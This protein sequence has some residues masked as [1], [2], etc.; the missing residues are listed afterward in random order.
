LL[1]KSILRRSKTIAAIAVASGISF[2]GLAPSWATSFSF[3]SSELT[4]RDDAS[5]LS[6]SGGVIELQL[7]PNAQSKAGG[8]FSNSKLN[9]NQNFVLDGE[10]YLGSESDGVGADGI[11]FTLIPEIPSAV[12]SDGD[13]MGYNGLPDVFAI[14]WDTFHN[15]SKGDLGSF[16]DDLSMALNK[17]DSNHKSSSP[18]APVQLIPRS[19]M[20]ADNGTYRDFRISWDAAEEEITVKYDLNGDSS[21]ASAETIFDGVNVPMTSTGGLFDSVGGEVHWG[22][23]ASTGL[24]RNEQK[25]RLGATKTTTPYA[26][27]IVTDI[28][29]DGVGGPFEVSTGEMVTVQG[30]RLGSVSS[31][32]IDGQS[33]AVAE[34][35]QTSFSFEMPAEV[36]SGLADIVVESNLGNLRFYEALL[37]TEAKATDTKVYDKVSA[38]TVNQDDGTAKVYVKFPTIGEKV[39]IGHQTGGSGAYETIYAKTTTSETMDGLRIVEGVGTYVVRT[40]DLESGTN[41]IRVTVGDSTEVQVRY[42]E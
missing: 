8:F 32:S 38:W 21:F 36:E 3:S 34:A 9:L 6:D 2:V 30:E 5:V 19:T 4:V 42:N 40:I 28:G 12:S 11:A 24:Y 17:G 29:G 35:T 7:T 13:G 27:P 41:R 25:I 39:R 22:F 18:Y 16:G 33:V 37:V 1:K 15:S 10:I 14:E 31:V 20:I 23:T 26:G